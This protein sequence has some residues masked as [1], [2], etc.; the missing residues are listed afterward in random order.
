MTH[1]TITLALPVYNEEANIVTVLDQCADA[2]SKLNQPWEILVV[3]NASSDTTA[4]LV[5][6]YA[7]AHPQVRLVK[8]EVNRLYSGSCATAIAHAQGQFIAIMD[9]DGQM[10]PGDIP[11]FM[12]RLQQG[13]DLVF[14]WRKDRR[15]PVSRLLISKVFNLL[16]YARIGYPLHDMNCGMR[17]FNRRYAD[18]A[19][20]QHRINMANPEL[21]VRA[22][23]QGL[24]ISEIP[25]RHYA[26]EK[27]KTSHNLLRL[28][29][30]FQEVD[31]YLKALQNDLRQARKR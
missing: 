14:G 15:D 22:V 2:L 1:P 11:H 27:G 5:A 19:R 13:D 21:Y 23:E 29:R 26:R 12:N 31:G 18:A 24:R 3:D 17:M 28:G 25:V 16:A 20:I 30:L 10:D 4:K 7:M 6:D 8:H 9:S